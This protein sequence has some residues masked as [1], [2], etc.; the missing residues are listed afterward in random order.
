MLQI[1]LIGVGYWGKN[2][3]R[4]LSQLSAGTLVAVCDIQ[5]EQTSQK[6]TSQGWKGA[7]YTN[8]ADF[9]KHPHL[10]AVVIATPTST[11]FPIVLACLLAKKHVLCE[12][13]LTTSSME[14]KQLE[15]VAKDNDVTL[16]VGHTYLFNPSV[17]KIKEYVETGCLGKIHTIYMTRTNWGPIREDVDVIWDLATHDVSILM[18]LLDEFP[19]Q[20]HSAGSRSIS[21]DKNQID[22]C[23]MTSTFSCGVIAHIHVSWVDPGKTRK[24]CIVG[25]HKK[26]VF[27]DMNPQGPITIYE[28]AK[29]DTPVFEIG[30]VYMDGNI[31]I[32]HI[33]SAE[34]LKTEVLEWIESIQLKIKPLSDASF[35]VD[36]VSFLEQMH[37]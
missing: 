20:I 23:F 32:P 5:S 33:A 6:I 31:T 19:S 35:A 18:Y 28:I 34:P 7:F 9:L 12:K 13:P 14:A 30:A 2:Y 24:I 4:L 37:A 3:L 36:V 11:H 22:T 15:I 29:K 17:R 1:G 10:Q 26:L 25:T 16:M 8:V 21:V 27:D